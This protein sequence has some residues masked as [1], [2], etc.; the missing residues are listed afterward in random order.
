MKIYTWQTYK[1]KFKPR[2]MRI[3][4]STLGYV[5]TIEPTMRTAGFKHTDYHMLTGCDAKE[6]GTP[7][8]IVKRHNLNAEI[9]VYSIFRHAHGYTKILDIYYK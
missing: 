8:E 2:M 3:Q 9:I 1:R 4:D 5:S 6:D 7:L